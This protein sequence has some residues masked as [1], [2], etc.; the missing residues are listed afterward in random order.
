MYRRRG[1]GFPFDGRESSVKFSH[2]FSCYSGDCVFLHY[3]IASKRSGNSKYF[4]KIPENL[5]RI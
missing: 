3:E 1:W 5:A 4:L 2:F